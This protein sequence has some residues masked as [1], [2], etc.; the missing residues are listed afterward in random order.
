ML[1]IISANLLKQGYGP[2]PK[3][4]EQVYD[5]ASSLGS[6]ISNAARGGSVTG[7]LMNRYKQNKWDQWNK[8]QQNSGQPD[9]PISGQCVQCKNY[10]ADGIKDVRNV[11]GSTPPAGGGP[12]ILCRPCADKFK[13]TA[14]GAPPVAGAPPVLPVP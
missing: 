9:Q 6:D 13:I 11:S 3:W 10:T 4:W 8:K 5:R 12:I 14:P 7:I 2:K 1:N